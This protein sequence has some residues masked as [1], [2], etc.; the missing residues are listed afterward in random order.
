MQ[1]QKAFTAYICNTL[2]CFPTFIRRFCYF[3][4]PQTAC[5]KKGHQSHSSFHWTGTRG[6]KDLV[7]CWR[8]WSVGTRRLYLSLVGPKMISRQSSLSLSLSN[9]QSWMQ[10]GNSEIR[11]RISL[12]ALSSPLS[13]LSALKIEIAPLRAAD[14]SQPAL[15]TTTQSS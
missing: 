4:G 15:L 5:L 10:T 12:S 11:R 3:F 2:A 8:H 1:R 14:V 7:Q 6:G 13:A 9:N